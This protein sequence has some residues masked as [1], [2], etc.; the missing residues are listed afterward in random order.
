MFYLVTG[1]QVW[2][3]GTRVMMFFC[4]FVI[5][6]L[7]SL[8]RPHVIKIYLYSLCVCVCVAQLLPVMN[9]IHIF[10]LNFDLPIFSKITCLYKIINIYPDLTKAWQNLQLRSLCINIVHCRLWNTYY[11]LFML[12]TSFNYDF[13]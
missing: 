11:V 4:Q 2:E 10:L 8:Y 1:K 5:F 13:R 9:R 7:E 6:S 3:L 12:F